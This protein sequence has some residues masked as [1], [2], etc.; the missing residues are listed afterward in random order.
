[1]ELSLEA[2]VESVDFDTTGNFLSVA[3]GPVVSLWQTKKLD[4]VTKLTE[5]KETVLTARFAP[6]AQFIATGGASR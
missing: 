1:M 2:G 6:S 5:E 4:S 3:A